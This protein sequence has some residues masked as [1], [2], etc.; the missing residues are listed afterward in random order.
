MSAR[1]QAIKAAMNAALLGLDGAIITVGMMR[2]FHTSLRAAGFV[3][4]PVEPTNKQAADG[5]RFD[6]GDMFSDLRHR[7][8]KAAYRAMIAAA[9]EP[10]NAK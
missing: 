4:V 8:F 6:S 9:Q 5:C 3:V 2:D 1:D 10:N 7:A